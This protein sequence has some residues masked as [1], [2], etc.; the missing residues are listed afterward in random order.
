MKQF[1][2]SQKYLFL[3]GLLC[4]SFISFSQLRSFNLQKTEKHISV[5]DGLSNRQI[6]SSFIDKN[7]Q[8]WFVTD[9]KIG[10]FEFGKVS[11]Y[12]LSKTFSHR[13]FNSVH[14][15][16][17]G[18]FWLSENFE[19]YYPFNVQ[20]CMIFN[21]ITHKITPIEAYI[22]QNIPIH[23]IISDAQH[24]IFIGTKTGE[25]YR[26]EVKEQTLQL[27]SSF[28]KMPVKLLYAGNKKLVA[29]LEKNDRS[30][31]T[32]LELSDDGKSVK[33]FDLKGQ[34]VRSVIE[35]DNRLFYLSF[36]LN[37][38]V[39]K[40]I[41]GSF[42]K[43]FPTFHDAYL[44]NILYDKRKHLFVV[45]EGNSLSFFDKQFKL[46][47]KEQFNF[48]IHDVEQDAYG[49]FILS[50]NN[51]VHIVQ[52]KERKFRTFLKNNDSENIN[53][54]F[55]CRKILKVD[56]DQ[57][58][59]NTNKRRQLIN[60]KT[61]LVKSLHDFKNENDVNSHFV[62]SSLKDK[63][64]TLIFGENA[65]VSTNILTMKDEVLGNFSNIKIWAIAEYKNGYLLGLERK[66]IIYYDNKTKKAT[67]FSTINP[68]FETSIIYDFFADKNGI[69]IASEAGF[70]Q[71]SHDGNTLKKIKFPLYE[72][73]Q[74]MCFS[75]QKDKKNPQQ[76][77]LATLNGIWIY[78]LQEQCIRPF[79]QEK[80][81]E[82][83]KYLSAYRTKNGVWASTEEGIWHFD[84][85]GNLMKIYTITDGLTSNECNRLAHFQDEND[86][87]YFG[88]INGLNILNPSDF[89]TKIE[90]K[91]TLKMDS[92]C[93]YQDT[94][95]SRVFANFKNPI[96]PL[97][98]GENTLKLIFSYEDFKYTCDKKYYYRTN[99]SLTKEWQ[100][101]NDRR[102]LLSNLEY[103]NTTIEIMAVSC[104]DFLNADT[105]KITFNR[106]N[107]L[108]LTW[109]FWV[110]TFALVSLLTW[111]AI[112]YST[113]QLK[114]RNK[115][116]QRK[117]DEQTLSLQESL[118][119]KETLL[120]LL[121]HDV[122]YPVQSFYGITKKMAYLIQK[123]DIERL[124][125]LGNET[126]NKSRKVLWLIDEL[127]YWV[128][129]T[130]T[131]FQINRKECHLGDLIQQIFEIYC[132]E[133]QKKDLNY[134]ISNAGNNGNASIEQ[135]LFIIVMRNLIFNSVIHSKAETKIS[136]LIESKHDNYQI[137]VTNEFDETHGD[138][139]KG[140]GIGLTLL[141]PILKKANFKIES[142]Q[143]DHVFTSK[144]FINH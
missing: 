5:A 56:N 43:R 22:H 68:T 122:R 117:V 110:I 103:G 132:D 77:L 134:S 24:Q 37:S 113:Y 36:Q 73:Q 20:R 74:M 52:I 58:I 61:G 137:I 96:L 1:Y 79:L 124:L 18:N 101:L 17:A 138:T 55:S 41:G 75:L 121:V 94:T 128:K 59:V 100:L 90:K 80:K 25:I 126:E 13:G 119:L 97:N 76:L 47:L 44:S 71:L 2:S 69:F 93:T 3:Y 4:L 78:D 21:P 46:V 106:P 33:P 112:K 116:L 144:L 51:G 129:G 45:N 53:E 9:N 34:F 114:R 135:G 62:L 54:N 142:S 12:L 92:I 125:L 27:I 115:L 38:A 83:K 26:L 118:N 15:D 60:L 14:E 127:V 30:D 67:P 50:T 11:N 143:N 88:G 130:N 66:G 109:Y 57:I 102:L 42:E 72:D 120:G 40:E 140:L 70:F 136:V 87:L 131:N 35:V 82:R 28:A 98:R 10:L 91:F 8:I 49:N 19:W 133:L 111:G 63:N 139:E 39:L 64:G 7:N 84:D 89:S 16:A 65:L 48:L 123:N 108:Y 86:V 141:L 81:Y 23:S 32:L 95:K 99:K 107:P 105:K 104:D 85:D 6:N 31:K 29:C